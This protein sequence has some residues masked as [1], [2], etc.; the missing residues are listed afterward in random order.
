MLIAWIEKKDDLSEGRTW[1]I[2][3]LLS[4]TFGRN[5]L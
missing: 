3:I 5:T 4:G 1:Q 2:L